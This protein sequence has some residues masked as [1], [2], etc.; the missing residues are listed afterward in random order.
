MTLWTNSKTSYSVMLTLVRACLCS[1]WSSEEMFQYFRFWK[2]A[3]SKPGKNHNFYENYII[4]MQVFAVMNYCEWR[5]ETL[6]KM[7]SCRLRHCGRRR[8][9]SPENGP[10]SYSWR[11]CHVRRQRRVHEWGDSG[12]HC[13]SSGRC[14][15]A[16]G[17]LH[18]VQT[19]GTRRNHG[20]FSIDWSRPIFC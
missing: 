4:I 20:S 5:F 16:L 6:L 8:F 11:S 12:S 9:P 2:K 1:V 15:V 19:N 13:G 14:D 10:G 17:P 18:Q 3:G 7:W